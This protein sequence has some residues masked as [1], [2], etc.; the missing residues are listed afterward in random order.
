MGAPAGAE[1]EDAGTR[2]ANH[3]SVKTEAGQVELRYPLPVS[4]VRFSG[5]G[6]GLEQVRML[7][8]MYVTEFRPD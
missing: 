6:F 8:D 7:L 4:A 2:D 1:G 5:K 3:V